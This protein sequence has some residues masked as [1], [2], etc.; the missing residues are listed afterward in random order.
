MKNFVKTFES[1]T[2]LKYNDLDVI[3]EHLKDYVFRE[4]EISKRPIIYRGLT[5][6]FKS[7]GYLIKT[8]DHIRKPANSS[9]GYYN[10][11]IDNSDEWKEYPKRSKS[12][13]CTN[14]ENVAYN[15][16]YGGTFYYIFPLCKNLSE[17]NIGVCP[18]SDLWNGS[19]DYLDDIKQEYPTPYRT[20]Y[21]TEFDNIFHFQYDIEQLKNLPLTYFED[22]LDS[23]RKFGDNIQ[24]PDYETIELIER[25]NMFLPNYA[26]ESG[27]HLMDI[28]KELMNPEEN[29]FSRITA[30]SISTYM[31]NKRNNEIWFEHDAVAI[32]SNYFHAIKNEL[33]IINV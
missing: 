26:Q 24:E 9:N 15:Y 18:Y 19:Q 20:T 33:N 25:Y 13:V 27:K 1:Y 31:E 6:R 3:Q 21:E 16:G 14:N 7:N 11:W 23:I 22:I 29:N 4:I 10:L 28:F 2:E 8:D 5:N 32:N 17:L 30:S 12:I